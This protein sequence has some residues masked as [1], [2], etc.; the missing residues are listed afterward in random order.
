[1]SSIKVFGGEQLKGELKV[2]GSKN[3]ALPIL[4][5]TVLLQGITILHNCPKI[6]DVFHMIKILEELGCK[7]KW[8]SNTLY[9]N[10]SVI[11][12]TSVSEEAVKKMRSS[13]LYLGALIGRYHEATI[14]YPGGCSIGK[15][16]IDYH[17]KAFRELNVEIDFYGEDES[18]IHCYTKGIL[19][20]DIFFEFPSVGATQNVILAAVL[21]KGVTRI[22][23]AAREPEVTELCNF[24]IAAGARIRGRGSAFLE[25]EGVKKLRDVEFNLSPDRIVAGTYMTAVAATCGDVIL[26]DTPVRQLDSIIRVLRKMGCNI[27]VSKENELRIR[28]D[29]RPYPVDVIKTKPYPGF[30]TDMQSQFMTVLCLAKGKSTIVEE[31]F[32]S[33]YQNVNEL[34][35]MGACVDLD[36]R[37]NKAIITGVNQ[38]HGAVVHAHDLRGGAALVIAGMAAQGVTIV[39]DATSIERGYE[40]ICRDFAIL[41]ANIRYCSEN[42]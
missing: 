40:D 12:R 28:S 41:G 18:M 5:A 39:R 32:E 42:A 25:I 15:R 27:T 31:I 19:G 23:N 30:P 4:A 21:S 36:E 34:I 24:L 3:A 11:T 7:T 26:L 8:E 10:S 35:K 1:M 17:L 29:I 16:P 2:Q 9:I 14:S 6:L 38:L 20:N 33:R 22:Y 13:V 37:E